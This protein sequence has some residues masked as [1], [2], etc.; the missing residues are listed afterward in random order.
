MAGLEK[1]Y[2]SYCRI[3]RLNGDMVI[4][5]S[6]NEMVNYIWVLRYLVHILSIRY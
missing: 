2:D 6:L 5:I 4:G 3:K 1:K